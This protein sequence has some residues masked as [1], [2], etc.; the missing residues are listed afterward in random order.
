ST[1]VGL[2]NVEATWYSSP[3]LSVQEALDAEVVED[4]YAYPEEAFMSEQCETFDCL[5]GEIR[6]L[7]NDQWVR[8]MNAG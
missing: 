4:P 1:D 7:Y 5:P 2:A 6:T 3:L 8:L